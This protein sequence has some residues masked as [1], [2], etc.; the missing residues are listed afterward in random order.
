MRAKG[1]DAWLA[2]AERGDSIWTVFITTV[3]EGQWRSR[4]QGSSQDLAAVPKYLEDCL[5]TRETGKG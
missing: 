5:M 4:R 3:W 2:L 1:D